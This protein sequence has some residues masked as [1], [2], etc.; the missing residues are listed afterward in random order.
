MTNHEYELLSTNIAGLEKRMDMQFDSIKELYN[1]KFTALDDTIKS[2]AKE[3][4]D[5]YRKTDQDNKRANLAIWISFFAFLLSL[6]FGIL[7]Y[8]KLC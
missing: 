7:N 4:I 1:E 2:K 8:I 6:V 5:E 3:V